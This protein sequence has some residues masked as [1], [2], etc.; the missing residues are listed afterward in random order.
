MI[1]ITQEVLNNIFDHA[2]RDLPNEACG[3]LA[4]KDGVITNSYALTNIDHSPEH[5]SFEPAEQFA[6]VKKIR[7]EGKDMLANYHSHPATP[8][9]PSVEDIRLAYDPDIFYFIISLATGKP[10]IKAFRII[11]GEAKNIDIKIIA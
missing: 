4:G 1:S 10:E 7:N 9:R 5:F 6:A 2:Q 11:N 3:Y 8:A